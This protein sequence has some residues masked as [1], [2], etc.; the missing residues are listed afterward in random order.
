M[1]Y[2]TNNKIATK[3]MS[4]VA[5]T[6]GNI[7]GVYD[8][9]GGGT[10]Y[11]MGVYTDGTDNWSG[12]SSTD[13]SGFNGCLGYECDYGFKTDGLEYPESKYYNSYTTETAYTNAGLQHA[14]VETQNWS[15]DIASFVTFS[16]SWFVRGGLYY[17]GSSAGIFNYYKNTGS[18]IN[19]YGLRSSLIIN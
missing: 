3:D 18:S 10:E 19:V 5:S 16:F 9:S 2:D 8:M 13:N 15:G 14:L 1:E 4:K 17:S 6:T 12:Y 11:V 7:Y